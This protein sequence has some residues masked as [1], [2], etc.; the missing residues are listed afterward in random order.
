MDNEI[1][2]TLDPTAGISASQAAPAPAA[3]DP[4]AAAA[5][6]MTAEIAAQITEGAFGVLAAPVRRLAMP[7]TPIP[8]ARELERALMPDAAS[9][10]AAARDL[11]LTV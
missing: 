6:A 3:P 8:S 10:A 2:L 11:A 1:K 4:L 7:D 9:I 5:A